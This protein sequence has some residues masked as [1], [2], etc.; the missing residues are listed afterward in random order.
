MNPALGDDFPVHPSPFG[1]WN[2]LDRTMSIPVVV[3]V[4][5]APGFPRVKEEGAIAA[6]HGRGRNRRDSQCA[7]E[8]ADG[9]AE[10]S[11]R[12]S[13]KKVYCRDDGESKIW[14]LAAAVDYSECIVITDVLPAPRKIAR[15]DW[16]HLEWLSDSIGDAFGIKHS[17]S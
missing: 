10:S 11:G 12:R 8:A 2:D 3:G 9:P 7:Q 15:L 5:C 4:S 6:A 1:D 17:Y 13:R 14:T 16:D